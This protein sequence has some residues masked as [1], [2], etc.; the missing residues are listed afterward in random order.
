MS[1]YFCNMEM[2]LR[3]CEDGSHTLFS[4]VSGECYHSIHG[5]Y[6]ESNHIFIQLGMLAH[7][8]KNLHILEVGFGT[9]LNAFLTAT[10]ATFRNMDVSYIG[11]E[12]FPVSLQLQQSLNYSGYILNRKVDEIRNSEVEDIIFSN[13]YLIKASEK[14]NMAWFNQLFSFLHQSAWSKSLKFEDHFLFEKRLEGIMEVS[15]PENSFDVIYF[16]AFSPEA[17]AELWTA[18]VFEKCY[19]LLDYNGILVTYCA[20][21]VVKRA[22]KAAGFIVENLPGP[23]GK[24]EITRAVKRT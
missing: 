15:L 2:E 24:R 3:L 23:P 1:L 9:G 16:D 14:M 5:A 8:K 21:G 19:R 20:K 12:P 10:E 6:T 4:T 11:L 13:D 18:E 17:Q 7:Q 22:L